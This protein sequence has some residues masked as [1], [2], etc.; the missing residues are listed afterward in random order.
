MYIIPQYY[1]LLDKYERQLLDE[2]PL[3]MKHLEE[4]FGFKSPN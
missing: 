2:I 3:M 1:V 4:K